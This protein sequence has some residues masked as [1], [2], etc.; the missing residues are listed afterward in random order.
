MLNILKIYVNLHNNLPSLPEKMK[1]KKCNKFV[2][3]LYNQ[4]SSI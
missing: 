1:D 2:C 4:G 3:N